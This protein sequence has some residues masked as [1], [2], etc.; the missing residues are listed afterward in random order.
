M[1]PN[2]AQVNKNLGHR[3]R[4]RQKFIEAGLSGFLDYEIVELLLTLGTPRRD[5]KQMAKDAIKVFGSLANVLD[6]TTQD[7][8]KIKGIGPSN[9]FG[10]KLMGAVSEIYS[11]QKLEVGMRLDNQQRVF[12]YLKKKIGNKKKEHF[13]ILCFDTRNKLIFEDVSV[14]TLNASLVH[15]R[16]VFYKAIQ[17]SASHIIVAHNHPS[18]DCTPSE[19]DKQTTKRLVE[20][21]KIIGITVVDHIIVTKNNCCSIFKDTLC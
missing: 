16:E 17:N 19:E 10:I 12:S 5:C 11:K 20:A 21:G 13:V 7:L 9:A 4:L 2:T 18:G 6:A 3:Q 14:G 15:P 1:M 8:T